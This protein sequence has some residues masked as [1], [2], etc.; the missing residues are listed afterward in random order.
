[1]RHSSWSALP[2]R[3]AYR[4]LSSAKSR[5]LRMARRYSGS[6]RRA[7]AGSGSLRSRRE[8]RRSRS[9]SAGERRGGGEGVDG[10]VA[11]GEVTAG[12]AVPFPRPPAAAA[13][14][15]LCN[16]ARLWAA[17][18]CCGVRPS[19]GCVAVSNSIVRA[20]VTRSVVVVIDVL[21]IIVWWGG[22]LVFC[23]VVG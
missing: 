15:S 11:G 6:S 12:V 3:A 16:S 2:R 10:R 14:S 7:S 4:S 22:V 13:A 17:Q 21:V 18:D 1:M 23:T 20:S 5:M 9:A 19:A 8:S